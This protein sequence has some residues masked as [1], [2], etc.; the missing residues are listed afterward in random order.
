[1]V[2]EVESSSAADE[3]T[4]MRSAGDGQYIFNLSTKRSQFAAGQDL[5]PGVY[6][7]TI[8]NTDFEDVV[9]L[10]TLRR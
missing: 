8:S 5:T 4:Q 2:N 9:V 3:G 1:M 10:F 7:L 6:R